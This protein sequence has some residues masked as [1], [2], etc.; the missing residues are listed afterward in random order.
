MGRDVNKVDVNKKQPRVIACRKCRHYQ[1]TW[2]P[3]LPYGCRAH[4]FKS[5]RNP[6]Q[7]VFESSGIECQL[8]DSKRNHSK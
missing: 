2:D 6:A 4:G 5:R 7:V 8:Y 1:V 3:S